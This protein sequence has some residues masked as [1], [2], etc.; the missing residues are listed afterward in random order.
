MWLAAQ[1]AKGKWLLFTDG[2]VIFA[3]DTLTRAMAYAHRESADH[4]VLYPTLDLHSAAERSLIGFF[5]TV[6]LAANRPW[7]IADARSR[8]SIGVG[9]F[10]MIRREAYEEIGTYEPLRLNVID[11]LSLGHRVKRHGLRQRMVIGPH[12]VRLRWAHSALGIMLNLE[13][14]FF[15]LM[16]FRLSLTI[17]ASLL[18]ILMSVGP[19]VGAIVAPG[20]SRLP[21]AV[22]VAAIATLYATFSGWIRISPFYFALH[23]FAAVFVAG[24][25]LNS[26]VHAITNRGIIWRGTKYSLQQLRDFLD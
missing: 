13:K 15:A 1:E 20:V 11:D 17:I 12:L 6:F 8:E 16:R 19:F 18:T 24:T 10:N 26:A 21:F 4:L 9:A 25:I 7:K 14:N 23:P 5:M 22:A 3:P 2:D